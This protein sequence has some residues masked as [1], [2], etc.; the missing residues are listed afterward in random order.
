[1]IESCAN[2][3]DPHG[4]NHESMLKMAKPR[5]CQQCH[6]ETSHP[7]QP[8][9][10]G[11]RRRNKFVLGSPAD[12]HVNIHGS[13][14]PAGLR[15]H[16]V[17]AAMR[18]DANGAA[19]L[20]GLLAL[21]ADLA[22][23]RVGGLAQ[24]QLGGFNLEGD[25]EAGVR[26]FIDGPRRSSWAKFEEYRDINSGLFLQGLRLRLF[27]P[28]EKYSGVL[29]GRQWGLTDQEYSLGGER[30]GLGGFGFELGPDP[31]HL[32]DQRPAARDAARAAAC[33]SCLTP[34]PR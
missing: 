33:S 24:T 26:F 30:L 34:R 23:R 2:C 18:D 5:L 8:L 7:D 1:M 6:I 9:R 21:A 20:A 32:L 17:G 22:A 15:L 13:N 4:S 29:G 14:H 16:A 27:T 31:A 10:A 3:H 25:A 12:C 11:H 19:V 28:D